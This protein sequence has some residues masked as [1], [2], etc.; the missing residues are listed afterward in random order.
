MIGH[1][2]DDNLKMD[3]DSMKIRTMDI[4]VWL[5]TPEVTSELLLVVGSCSC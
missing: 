4:P 3:D 1:H 5:S 2:D